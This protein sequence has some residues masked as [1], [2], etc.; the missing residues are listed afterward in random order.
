MVGLLTSLPALA[1][2]LAQVPSALLVDRYD[3][4]LEPTLKS[5]LVSRSFYLVLPSLRLPLCH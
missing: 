1:T 3:N 5:S 2:L 4:R